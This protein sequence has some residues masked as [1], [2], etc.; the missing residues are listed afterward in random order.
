MTWIFESIDKERY[1]RT[2]TRRP[3]YISLE[4]R[5]HEKTMSLLKLIY[6]NK[7]RIFKVSV[8][9]LIQI[10]LNYRFLFLSAIFVPVKLH[11]QTDFNNIYRSGVADI[12]S[13]KT[14]SY[15]KQ[16]TFFFNLIIIFVDKDQPI[17]KPG[18]NTAL[19]Y[20]QVISTFPLFVT[21]AFS[22]VCF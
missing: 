21:P 18:Y 4:L 5:Y 3:P 11:I 20:S 22:R 6:V 12:A 16:H 1:V 7:R 9:T 17:Q 14:K 10:I 8:W 13:N 2:K 19:K 15:L